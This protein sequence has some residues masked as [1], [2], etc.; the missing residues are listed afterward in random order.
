MYS[1]VPRLDV[2][3]FSSFGILRRLSVIVGRIYC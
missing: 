1:I 3:G 2:V